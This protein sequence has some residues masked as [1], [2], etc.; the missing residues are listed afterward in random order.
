MVQIAGRLQKS[1]AGRAREVLKNAMAATSDPGVRQ[2]AQEVI[3]RLEP[4]EGY[5]LDWAG[6]GPY[7]QKDKNAQAL[8]DIAFPPE[9][10]G[11][12]GVNWTRIT[13]GVGAWDINLGEALGSANNAVGY[14]RTRI[15]SPVGQEARMECGSDDGIKAWLNGA[16]VHA[17]NVERGLAPRQDRV[18]VTLKQGWNDLLLKVTNATGGW[19][20]ACRFRQPDGSSLD[21]LKVE[22]K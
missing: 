11:A 17:N 20:C 6:A 22:A 8:F 2:Q 16:V 9:Q 4:Y 1:E 12:T 21:D 5:I 14:L 10:P 19:A 3:N 18:K 7:Q 13:K 15:W